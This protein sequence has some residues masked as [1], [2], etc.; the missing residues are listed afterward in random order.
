MFSNE[1]TDKG[2]KVNAMCPGWVRT[3]MGGPDAPRSVNEGADT[4]VWLATEKYIPTGKFFMDRK[5]ISW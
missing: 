2:I 3:E 1:L 5:E 4:A